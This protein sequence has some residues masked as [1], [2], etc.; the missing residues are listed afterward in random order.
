MFRNTPEV[1][2]D[3]KK[4]IHAPGYIYSLCLILYEDFHLDLNK[5]HEVNYRAKL[6]V[7]E[8]SLIIGFLVQQ[9]FDLSFP[10]SLELTFEWK[11]QTYTL[12]RELQASFSAPQLAKLRD[13]IERQQNGEVFEDEFQDRL[14][15][16]VKDN[17]MV[18]PMFYAGDGVYDFQYLEY[19]EPKYK[20][21]RD[22]LQENKGFNIGLTREIVQAIKK[23]D[24]AKS[25]DVLPVNVKEVFPEIA[26][27]ARKKLK[28]QQLSK[29]KIDEIERQQLIFASFYRYRALFPDP[30]AT[31]NDSI[32]G[33]KIFYQN[34][35]ELFVIRPSDLIGIDHEAV[36]HFFN[37]FSF[38][39]VCNEAYEGP[40]HYNILNSRPLIK[41]EDE[42]YLLP[43]GYL[44]PEAVYE[45]P[46]YWMC[47]DKKYRDS[48]AK[49][50]GDVGEEIAYELLSKVFG[51]D[52]TY[53]SVL[54]ETKK[55]QRETDI[56]VL[57]LLGNKAL[58]VQVKSKKLTLT[59]KRGDFEQLSKDFKGAVQD[60]YG[61]GLVSRDAILNRKARFVNA[62][63][64][65]LRLPDE[66]SEV[67]IMG[68]TTE[69]YPTLAHQV[70]MMLVKKPEDPYPL[71]VSAF[72]LE[73]LAH[74]L[75][76]PYD[77]LYYVRQRTALMEYFR[78]DE[79]LV[80]L[81][82]H[83]DQK[84]WPRE[85]FDFVSIETDFGGLIDR[86]YY[87]YKT[88]MSH[89]LSEKD[90]LILNSWKD[91]QFDS[92]IKAIKSA[93]DPR[94]TDIIFQLLDWSGD[95]RKEIVA[96]M[97]RLKQTSRSEGK[98][99]S[100]ATPPVSGFGLSYLVINRTDPAE[101]ESRVLTYARLRKYLS[102]CQT[103]LGLGAFSASPNL[104]DALVFLDEPWQQ[105]AELES[106]YSEELAK[107]KASSFIP[108]K[109]KLKVGRNDPCPCQSGKKFKKCC[110][111]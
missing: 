26:A 48:L 47:D 86:N 50:R 96:Y 68:L 12:M 25:R 16:F 11:E 79:E 46:F 8:C 6:S 84:L 49:H 69:N 31:S 110:G 37:N 35:L 89:L 5:I 9:E 94:T 92:F 93:G 29:E 53:Q 43:I 56:D 39:P 75:K 57:C 98:L 64:G 40:G 23:L 51:K 38:A 22:W 45:S 63:G 88:G 19:L 24:S 44:L 3:L 104:I 34:L 55:G 33:W 10:E 2:A 101:L 67:Y 109:G 36:S 59:A 62:K 65:E 107:M 61:Q 72:D 106:A 76:D 70:H 97:N 13:M 105:D 4:L 100:L 95:A 78:A 41:L 18:E 108:M 81:G 17:G 28:K 7:K 90:D 54:V 80:Y 14:D 111:G 15:F 85:G 99:K 27:K 60:A 30:E 66:I 83:L 21:D 91:P 87:P 32:E 103:W 77:F 1:L 52:N 58:C 71:F 20:Y 74:Y 102:K 73:L 82:Y 42:R